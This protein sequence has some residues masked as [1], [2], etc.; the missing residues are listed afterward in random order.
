[1]PA[2]RGFT[3][4][5]AF[6]PAAIQAIYRPSRRAARVAEDAGPGPAYITKATRRLLADD[7]ST[8]RP[9][10][11]TEST[12]VT[13]LIRTK[14]ATL[15]RKKRIGLIGVLVPLIAVSVIVG[16]GFLAP[17]TTENVPPVVAAH[18]GVGAPGGSA[19]TPV[20]QAAAEL[21][22]ASQAAAD[23]LKTDAEVKAAA[24]AKAAADAAALAKAQEEARQRQMAGPESGDPSN[25]GAPVAVPDGT[26]IFPVQNFKLSSPF[27]WRIHPIY[28]V[29]KFHYGNDLSPGCNA[30]IVAAADGVVVKA[31]WNGDLGYYVRLQNNG[32]STGYAHQARFVVKVGQQVKQGEVIGYVGTTGLSTGCHLHWEAF[33]AQGKYFDALT[34]VH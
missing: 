9:G 21:S 22:A 27:G 26:V 34:L 31:G 28:H 33:N 5:D 19:S 4:G 14:H 30:P 32:F 24:K 13:T 7:T 25:V 23:A 6:E 10:I 8:I 16:F 20:V 12:A 1:M 2:R 3:E 18:V 29:F 11:H 17:Q 15:S